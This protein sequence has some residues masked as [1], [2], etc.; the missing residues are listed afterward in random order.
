MKLITRAAGKRLVVL[1]VIL[2]LI[3][4][5]GWWTMMRMPSKSFHG[6]LPPLTPVQTALRDELRGHV[7]KLAV[8]IGERNVFKPAKLKAAA[9]YIQASLTSDGYQVTRQ[10]FKAS[11]EVCDNLEVE[12]PGTTRRNEIIVIGAHYD[13]VMGTAGAD[14]NATG[15]AGLL[16]LARIWTNR[17]PDRTLRFVAFVNEEPPFFQADGM[18]SLVYAKQCR[19][20]GDQVVAMISLESLGYFSMAKQS[21]KYPPPLGLFYPSRGDFV[22]FVGNSANT[23]LVRRCVK[24][25]CQNAQFP[26][27]GGA[28][29][30]WLPG[31]GWSDHWAFW[32]AGYP[33][34][35]VT[36]TAPFRNPHYHTDGDTPDK[37]D[38]DRLVRVVDGVDKVIEDLASR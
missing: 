38:Y 19:E 2:S 12:I 34:L 37:L 29:P 13:S 5:A 14:D 20:R 3:V 22:A 24:T 31:I 17:Q 4:L 33:A 35:M 1:A 7:E 11:G 30:G 16:A 32:Q 28:L 21:Q 26:C 25:F 18:G 10:S 23:G 27:E 6:P 15:V 36:D 8:E 9:N